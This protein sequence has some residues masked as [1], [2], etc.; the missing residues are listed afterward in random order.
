[1]AKTSTKVNAILQRQAIR[2][3]LVAL[4]LGAMFLLNQYHPKHPEGS[5]EIFLRK[6]T[7]SKERARFLSGLVMSEQFIN[8]SESLVNQKAQ[9]SFRITQEEGEESAQET[10]AGGEE[11]PQEAEGGDEAT[12]KGEKTED[13]KEEEEVEEKEEEEVAEAL[14]IYFFSGALLIGCL[15]REIKKRTGFPY[16][17]QLLIIGMAI[18]GY[19]R[20]LGDFGIAADIVMK[21]NPEGI[22]MIFIPTIIFESAFNTDPYVF[23]KELMQIIILAVP[24]VIIGALI[25]SYS[26]SYLLGYKNEL[27]FYGS[28]TFGSIVCATDP[29]AVVALLKELG[30]PIKFNVLLEGESLLNDGTAMISYLVFSG[31]FKKEKLTYVGVTIR[32]IQLCVGGPLVGYVAQQISTFWL[33]KI[34]KDDTLTITITFLACYASFYLGEMYLGVSGILTIVTLGVLMGTYGKL[35]INP[36]SQ[37]ALHS[38]WTFVQ[39]VLETILFLITGL[40]IGKEFIN[41]KTSTITK[42]DWFKMFAFFGIMNACRLIM[43]SLLYNLLNQYGYKITRKDTLV[44]SYGGLRGAI[45]LSLA[46][47]VATDDYPDRFKELVLFYL[48]GMITLTVLVNGLT[49]KFFMNK[50][51]FLKK[52]PMKLKS[53]K[54]INQA[55]M[56]ECSTKIQHLKDNRFFN[57][58]DW[59]E[60]KKITKIDK[61]Q[62]KSFSHNLLELVNR[63]VQDPN[64]RQDA[65]TFNKNIRETRYQMYK[66]LKAM[67]WDKFEEHVCSSNVASTLVDCC[68]FCMEELESKIWIWK[69]MSQHIFTPGN[70]SFWVKMKDFFLIGRIA[71]SLISNKLNASYELLSTL[72]MSM[73][74]LIEH[75]KHIQIDAYYVKLVVAEFKQDMNSAEEQLFL[76]T[77]LYPDLIAS[78]QKRQACHM[79]LNVQR[80]VI[81]EQHKEGIIDNS[82]H[83]ERITQIDKDISKLQ[84][85]KLD[86]EFKQADDMI[87]FGR[88]FKD[89]TDDDMRYIKEH[90]QEKKFE[91]G[92]NIYQKGY[93]IDG[94]FI[95]AA[96]VVEDVITTDLSI[97]FGMGS[98]LSYAHAIMDDDKA[99][100]SAKA[101]TAVTAYFIPKSTMDQVYENS[102]EFR[103]QCHKKALMYYFKIY[104]PINMA[105]KLD[106]EQIQ[107]LAKNSELILKG[108]DEMLQLDN[109]GFLL[110]GHLKEVPSDTLRTRP[111][112]ER[113]IEP[114]LIRPTRADFKVE[115]KCCVLRFTEKYDLESGYNTFVGSLIRKSFIGRSS[116]MRSA[117]RR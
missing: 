2:Y 46:L 90:A 28:L 99:M 100:T 24:G 7:Q 22:L 61:M 65:A 112:V 43:I 55:L 26:F 36:H 84:Y 73:S 15:C 17:P 88:V 1:M 58:A 77:D 98:L 101:V 93:H 16:T 70:M 114:Q 52:D 34:T 37:H 30:T 113:K 82:Q 110:Y 45:A 27:N 117:W 104:P 95:I 4:G 102:F 75:K 67:I 5:A 33:K 18:G 76:M 105:N 68:D 47:M 64:S 56:R 116:M 89:I 8:Q 14:V 71:K 25:L 54:T 38:V 19:T 13:N 103:S 115:K 44:L 10:E 97:R 49:M 111:N 31:L 96:G 72:I 92:E 41:V 66:Q 87:M 74:E 29:V 94:V 80:S 83:D 48:A 81:E 109:G 106:D 86:W 20:Y 9:K 35:K 42:N 107:E 3:L 11:T 53:N 59:D 60:V 51:N 85:M 23:R 57:L 50:I 62:V 32:L 108:K 69:N 79:I 21:V 12:K 78:I 39:Y 6:S 40:Y 63:Q 91:I